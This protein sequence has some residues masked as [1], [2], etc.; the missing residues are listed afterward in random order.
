M[1]YNERNAPP[2]KQENFKKDFSTDWI[3]D[4]FKNETIVFAEKFG[5]YLVENR[6]T[7]SQIRNI[8]G[9]VKRI[10]ANLTTLDAK[11]ED[12]DKKFRRCKKDILLLRPKIAYAAIRA[13]TR[14]IQALQEV[15]DKA[16]LAIDTNTEDFE[17][18]KNQFE[19]FADFFEA[20]LAYHKASG[21][22]E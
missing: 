20:V 13:G 17:L 7:T 21:G 2:P 6:L 5:K 19:N 11:D 16:H 12:F 22:R 3:T 15:M 1:S 14:G 8:Y 4:K 9:E 10:E 18:L